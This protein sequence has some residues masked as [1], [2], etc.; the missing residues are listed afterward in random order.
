MAASH[1]VREEEPS[2]DALPDLSELSSPHA[3]PFDSSARNRLESLQ[4][5]ISRVFLTRDP[6][7]KFR[8]AAQIIVGAYR[9]KGFTINLKP[10][11]T[12][13]KCLYHFFTYC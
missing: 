2:G 3:Y 7:Y 4:T 5:H 11:K 6:V 10:R 1:A 9:S 12:N 8:K 13:I